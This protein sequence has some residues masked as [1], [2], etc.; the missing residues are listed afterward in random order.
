MPKPWFSR[1]NQPSK[2]PSA[3]LHRLLGL[4][5]PFSSWR[6]ERSE[7]WGKHLHMGNS[8]KPEQES[9]DRICDLLRGLL[10]SVRNCVILVFTA[11]NFTDI[12]QHT[13]LSTRRPKIKTSTWPQ[14]RSVPQPV[15]KDR[16]G[17]DHLL[18]NEAAGLAK[19]LLAPASGGCFRGRDQSPPSPH[20]LK[21]VLGISGK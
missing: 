4:A 15:F 12:G 21:W 3:Q 18:V 11:L 20:I 13:K 16:R 17:P 10:E 9:A 14:P 8:W 6:E 1:R 19:W 5:L 7:R 2:R